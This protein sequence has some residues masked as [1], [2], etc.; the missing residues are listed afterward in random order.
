MSSY[1]LQLLILYLMDPSDFHC[2]SV[3]SH[4]N[5]KKK[6]KKQKPK[7]LV[8]SSA[9]HLSDFSILVYNRLFNSVYIGFLGGSP[10]DKESACQH[11]GCKRLKVKPWVGTIPWSRKWHPTPVSLPGE[12]HGQRSLVDYSPWGCKEMDMADSAHTHLQ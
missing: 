12:C 5:S 3:N 8:L 10:S 2:L 7:T 1:Y 4:S 9:I 11:R 6:N